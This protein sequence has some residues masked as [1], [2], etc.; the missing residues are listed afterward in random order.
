MSKSV[1]TADY[2]REQLLNWYKAMEVVSTGQEY[3]I[4]TR[5]LSMPHLKE[6]REQIKYWENKL[7]QIQRGK[8]GRR[9]FN[10]VPVDI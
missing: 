1:I 6:I 9:T 3:K 7:Q 8:R 10:I 2:A 5:T 4:G